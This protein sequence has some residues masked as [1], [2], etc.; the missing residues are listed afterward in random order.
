MEK[1]NIESKI[2]QLIFKSGSKA[3]VVLESS[4]PGTKIAGGKYNMGT[5]TITLFLEEIKEQCLQL[6]ASMDDF[7]EYV[8]IVF[9]HELGHAEDQHLADLVT[10]YEE[11]PTDEKRNEIS[12]QIEENAWDFAKRLLHEEVQSL[13][14]DKIIDASLQSYREKVLQPS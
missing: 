9:A 2:N 10:L 1:H 12:L 4:Y 3:Q 5:H 6:F 14:L 11:S 8:A 7:E 13:S